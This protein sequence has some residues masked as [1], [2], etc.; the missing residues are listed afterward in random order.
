MQAWP[1]IS[2]A[3]TRW[4]R[5]VE[6]TLGIGLWLT[7]SSQEQERCPEAL[8]LSEPLGGREGVPLAEILLQRRNA[9]PSR[10][11]G[12]HRLTIDG[13]SKPRKPRWATGRAA[14]LSITF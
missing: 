5:K 14:S 6:R 4:R 9:R 2:N 11:H 7:A 10:F 3:F 12:P 1:P 13:P 8:G